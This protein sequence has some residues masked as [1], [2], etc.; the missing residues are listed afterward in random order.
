MHIDVEDLRDFYATRLGIL[1]KRRL[2]G[3][4]RA[5]WQDRNISCLVG[6]GF[7]APYLAAAKNVPR[8]GAMMPEGQGA[9]IWP[10]T[11]NTKTLLDSED[12]LPLPDNSVDQFLV[13]HSLEVTERPRPMLREIWRVLRPEGRVLIVFPNRRVVWCRLDHTPFGHGS[14]FSRNQVESLLTD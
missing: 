11:G 7:A 2:S 5:H 10:D 13:T 12:H 14:T 4:I 3:H 1:V 6:L 9:L 8:V